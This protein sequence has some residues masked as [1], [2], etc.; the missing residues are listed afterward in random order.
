VNVCFWGAER[1][2]GGG[3]SEVNS[4]EGQRN[5]YCTKSYMHSANENKI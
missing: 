2:G 5:R 4:V 1:E 3:E